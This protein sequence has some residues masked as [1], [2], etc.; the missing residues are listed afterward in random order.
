MISP[1]GVG[2]GG[3]NPWW[4]AGQI[5]AGNCVAAYRAKGAASYMASKVNLANPGT[6]DAYEGVQPSWNAEDGWFSNEDAYLKT[7]ITADNYWTFIVGIR[8]GS[9]TGY[10]FPF[11]GRGSG[12]ADEDLLLMSRGGNNERGYRY[13]QTAYLNNRYLEAGV[14]CIAGN[15]TYLNGI[16]DE[17]V[18]GSILGI[19]TNPVELY[20][21]GLNNAGTPTYSLI[22]IT[23]FSAYNIKLTSTQVQAVTSRIQALAGSSTPVSRYDSVTYASTIGVL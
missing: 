12:I 2:R 3:S 4:L 15:K 9:N 8:G 18:L 6:Y 17:E 11:G 7:G 13:G 16:L 5:G 21:L 20:L 19:I 1:L 14:M 10:G 23:A 22:G